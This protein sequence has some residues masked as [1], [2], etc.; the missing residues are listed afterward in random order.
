[1][2]DRAT[3]FLLSDA[4]RNIGQSMALLRALG[5]YYPGLV[6]KELPRI[7]SL[8]GRQIRLENKIMSQGPTPQLGFVFPVLPV[9]IGGMTTM[10]LPPSV[11]YRAIHRLIHRR[12]FQTIVSTLP[13]AGSGARGFL[14]RQP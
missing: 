14:P 12:L 5:P 3:L 1:M 4:R 2:N 7:R 10:L 13:E 6:R 9:I 11:I 8:A